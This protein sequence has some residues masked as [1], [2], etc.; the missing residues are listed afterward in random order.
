MSERIAVI[1]EWSVNRRPSPPSLIGNLGF[2][3]YSRSDYQLGIN[4]RYLP[5][6]DK[7]RWVAF[8]QLNVWKY[9]IAIGKVYC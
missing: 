7:K 4:F 2:R 5:H 8:I 3:I 6:I 9:E 1:K